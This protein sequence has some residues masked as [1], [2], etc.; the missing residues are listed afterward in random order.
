[1]TEQVQTMAGPRN[2]NGVNDSADCYRTVGGVHF[3]CWTSDW[4]KKLVTAYRRAGVRC[5]IFVGEVFIH[6]EDQT[7]A[8]SVDDAMRA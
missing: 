7:K 4:D 5:R 8:A 3:I 6:S 1:M 2:R